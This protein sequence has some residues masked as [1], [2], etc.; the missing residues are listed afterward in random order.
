M[1]C[2]KSEELIENYI[3]KSNIHEVVYRES[4][5]KPFV[6]ICRNE[7]D[8]LMNS[9]N[10]KLHPTL[11]ILVNE[12]G[13]ELYDIRDCFKIIVRNKEKRGFCKL[14]G[15]KGKL[16]IYRLVAEAW[17]GKVAKDDEDI[18]HKDF[19]RYNNHYKNLCIISIKKHRQIH[20]GVISVAYTI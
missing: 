16:P 15:Y 19:N 14:S 6:Y 13:T 1:E 11:P 18:H 12:D 2:I 3:K 9:D 20:K 17:E 5:H 4:S 8:K 7:I 10:F